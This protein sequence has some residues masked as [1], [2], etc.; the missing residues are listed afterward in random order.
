MMLRSPR[1]RNLRSLPGIAA[2]RP[3]ALTGLYGNA[4]SPGRR[5]AGAKQVA[6]QTRR[7]CARTRKKRG[8]PEGK[9]LTAGG[10]GELRSKGA[11]GPLHTL[12]RQ[13]IG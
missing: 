13:T 7:G 10:S 8:G 9:S 3:S 1:A 5:A 6:R 11:P 2:A 12:C 4:R